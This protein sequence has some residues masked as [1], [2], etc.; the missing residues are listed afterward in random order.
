[1]H[2]KPCTLTAKTRAVPSLH[3][4]IP[5]AIGILAKVPGCWPMLRQVTPT[6]FITGPLGGIAHPRLRIKK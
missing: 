6:N 3:R 2:I 5:I 1:M 4:D